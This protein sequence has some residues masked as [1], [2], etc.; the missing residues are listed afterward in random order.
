VRVGILPHERELPQPLE[1]DLRVGR[2]DGDATV[3]DYRSLY[4]L[5]SDTVAGD[6]HDYLERVAARILTRVLAIDGVAWAR[7]A[8]RK[9]HVALAG[10]LAYAEVTLE[11]AND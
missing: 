10:P 4:H 2:R 6:P 8:V 5:V 7:V 1:V 11:D 9:P 3:L